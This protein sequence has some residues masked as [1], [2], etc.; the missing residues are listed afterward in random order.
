MNWLS[1]KPFTLLFVDG[2]HENFDRLYSGEFEVVDFHGGKTHKIAD[3][4]YHLMRDYVFTLCGKKFF[5]FVGAN[6]HDIDDG[7]L[8]RDDFTSERE[9]QKNYKN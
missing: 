6:S 5:V 4:I 9:F 2:N 7:I 1:Q 3:N 8:D